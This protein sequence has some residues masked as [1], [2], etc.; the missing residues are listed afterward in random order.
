MVPNIRGDLPVHYM[1]NQDKVLADDSVT[2]RSS[3]SIC[4]I[5]PL[6]H[7]SM[8]Q[9]RGTLLASDIKKLEAYGASDNYFVSAGGTTSLMRQYARR[10][11]LFGHIARLDAAVP[12]HQAL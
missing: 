3:S 1:E 11:S 7:C 12:A 2:A 6:Y 4:G 5:R 8:G 10:T 9:R